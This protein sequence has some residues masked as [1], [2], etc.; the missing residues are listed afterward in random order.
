MSNLP[1]QQWIK[2]E[3]LDQAPYRIRL[4][5]YRHKMNQNESPWDWPE[6]IKKEVTNRLAEVEWNR[7]P[8]LV[9]LELRAR[10]AEYLRLSPEMILLGKGSN[11][12]LAA[13]TKVVLRPGDRMCTLAP[14]FPVY[15]MLGEQMQSQIITSDL[16]SAYAVDE[17]DLLPKTAAARLTILCNP[18]SPTGNLMSLDLIEKVAA[19]AEGLVIVDE[20]Y[21]DFSRVTAI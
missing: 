5:G 21:Y 20:A 15:R 13:L 16:D 14:T 4:S 3:V 18:N 12:V 7:Y 10:L 1:L 6:Q 8:P 9:P 2:P 17:A 19:T 11:E